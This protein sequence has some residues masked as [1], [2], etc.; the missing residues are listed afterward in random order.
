LINI[1][2]P[3]NPNFDEFHYI[4]SAK[5]FLQLKPNQNWEHP[6]LAKELIAIGIGIWG[7]RPIGWRYMST[8]FGSLTL[9]GMYFWALALFRNQRIALWVAL[10][11]LAN[12]LLYVQ[13]RIGML[14]TFMFA[15]IVWA[16]AAFTATWHPV[17]AKITYADDNSEILPLSFSLT[18]PKIRKFLLVAGICL[19]LGTAC[20][21]F[22]VIPWALCIGWVILVRLFQYWKTQ[23]EQ[24]VEDDW[25]SMDLWR[26]LK[27]RDWALYLGVIPLAAY[28]ATFLPYLLI[29]SPDYGFF[30]IFTTMQYKMWDGQGRV[31]NSH[32]YM[33][34]WTDWATLK[35]PIW[36][37]FD[38]AGLNG[39]RVR[40]VILLGNPWVL[41]TGLI[42]WITCIWSWAQ[43]R[44]R[45]AFIIFTAFSAF[46]LSWAIIPR[47]VA[48]F[49]YYYPAGMVLSLALGFVFY[50][51]EKA[52]SLRQQWPRWVFL[53]VAVGVFVYFFPISAA[54]QIPA[55]TFRKWMW[56]SSWI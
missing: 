23:F 41:W 33:S 4:P 38:K 34:T 36:Y 43:E 24:P 21:W 53:A 22:T 47:K 11:T 25:F 6:P 40:G 5:Q 46:Y 10:I 54:L 27:W 3:S 49:Y 35:R 14:D 32:P 51:G 18:L 19:G 44:R 48:F 2:F 31:V 13:S 37:A 1:Q 56:R 15:F 28:F 55:E 17:G 30:Q 16:M 50:H 29:D 45:D 9:I 26:G 39:D 20:K 8:F 12:Q 42:A 52:F 7:D